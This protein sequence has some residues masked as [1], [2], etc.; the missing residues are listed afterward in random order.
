MLVYRILN[1]SYRSVVTTT[2]L[3]NPLCHVTDTTK[4]LGISPS[5]APTSPKPPTN[6][7]WDRQSMAAGASPSTHTGAS[8][9]MW[10]LKLASQQLPSGPHGLWL[11]LSMKANS[12]KAPQG[13]A[14]CSPSWCSH[15]LQGPWSREPSLTPPNLTSIISITCMLVR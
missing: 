1:L 4:L 12:S 6:C 14:I 5:N 9:E 13:N 2:S 8:L 15:N 11:E 7:A 3:S 10:G